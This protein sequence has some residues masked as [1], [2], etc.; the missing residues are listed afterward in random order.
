[1]RRVKDGFRLMGQSWKVIRREPGLVG[2]IAIGMV[3]SLAGMAVLYLLAFRRMPEVEDFRW[4]GVLWLYPIFIVAGIPGTIAVGTVIATSMQSI[5]GEDASIRAGFTL[6]LSKL[7]RLIGWS[8]IAS[9]VG[10]LI[11]LV[12][13]KLKMGGRIAALLA[14]VSWAVATMLVVPVLLFE[15]RGPFDA[16]KRSGSLVK[17]RWGEGVAGYGSISLAMAVMMVPLVLGG[18][19]L[20]AVDLALGVVALAVVALVMVFVTNAMV[21][22][23]GA[24]L[25]RFATAGVA[26]GPFGTS[27]LETTFV[28]KR[29]RERPARRAWRLVGVVLL[30][31]YL[32][33]K[34]L[35]WTDVISLGGR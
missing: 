1:M 33:V 14:G 22:V 13:E 15:D 26:G 18:S 30:G 19:V 3:A 32:V 5:E 35:E 8:L 16:L 12:A 27:Q 21:G 11:Q 10:I 34:V 7:P 28:T 23:F 25:Y 2:V 4:P 9:V 31:I 20:V 6:T 29:E 24:A 17:E